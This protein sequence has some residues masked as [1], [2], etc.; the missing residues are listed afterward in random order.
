MR[1]RLYV[2]IHVCIC[3][4]LYVRICV[5]VYVY[6]C[7]CLRLRISNFKNS[8]RNEVKA[9]TVLEGKVRNSMQ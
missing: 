1:G 4:C 3:V 7:R 2:S 6:V 9:L 5:Y 8:K